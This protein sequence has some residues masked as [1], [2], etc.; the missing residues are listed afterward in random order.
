MELRPHG[1]LWAG[2]MAEELRDASGHT[3]LAPPTAPPPFINYQ[4]GSLACLHM[5]LLGEVVVVEA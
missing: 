4:L 5:L 3:A 2:V 1:A